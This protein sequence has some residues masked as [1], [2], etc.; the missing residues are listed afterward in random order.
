MGALNSLATLG[1][2]LALNQRAQANE[3]KDLRRERDRQIQA[4]RI[5]DAEEG[6]QQEQALRRRLAEE[7]ARAGG[8]GV[9]SS[10]GSADAILA[11]LVQ[12]SRLREQ[13][14]RQESNLE[15]EDIR[16]TFDN[17]SQ[18]SLLDFAG[19]SVRLGSRFAGS[20]RSGRSLLD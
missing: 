19:R 6:R 4:I 9:G 13:A 14:R 15:I 2:N 8:A 12:E 10:G 18:R 20:S 5:G 16:N 1:L 3:A 7:R 17:R 11:G